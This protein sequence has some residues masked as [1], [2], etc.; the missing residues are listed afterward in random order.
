MFALLLSA[1][2][3][4][5]EPVRWEMPLQVLL[6]VL[7]SDGKPNAPPPNL[8]YPHL[9]VLACN[10]DLLWMAEAPTPRS[11]LLLNSPLYCAPKGGWAFLIYPPCMESQGCPLISHSICSFLP[12]GGRWFWCLPPVWNLRAV[13]LIP[14]YCIFFLVLPS[15]VA[16]SVLSFSTFVPFSWPLFS[17]TSIFWK[18]SS[19]VWLVFWAV[20]SWVL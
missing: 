20:W 19:F 2:V 12:K 6:D 14:F 5:G 18:V 13:S 16:F 11:A 15:L 7:M 3:L 4:F 9:P 1:L 8:P 10:M 17:Q